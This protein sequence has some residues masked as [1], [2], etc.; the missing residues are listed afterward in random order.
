MKRGFNIQINF[1]N[2]FLYTFVAFILLLIIGVGVFALTPGIAPNPGHLIDNVAP[3]SPCSSGQVLQ[4]DGSGWTCT[5]QSV[6]VSNSGDITAVTAG[7]GL[8]GGGTSG[9]VTLSADTTYLQR[10]VS[11]SCPSGQSIRAISSTGS[12][13]CEVD[14]TISGLI[15]DTRIRTISLGA[16][17]NGPTVYGSGHTDAHLYEVQGSDGVWRQSSGCFIHKAGDN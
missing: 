9:S 13:T 5:D 7:T 11:G 10:R 8:S 12:V 16:C 6:S 14:D 17:I 4:W 1:T 3:P 2:R 15:G